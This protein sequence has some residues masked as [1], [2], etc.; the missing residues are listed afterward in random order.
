MVACS[1]TAITK[2]DFIA[3]IDFI[4]ELLHLFSECRRFARKTWKRERDNWA[5]LI[6]TLKRAC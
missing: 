4:Q 3:R 1:A 2:A 6:N 5:L